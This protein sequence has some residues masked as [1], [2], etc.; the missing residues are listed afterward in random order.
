MKT[1]KELSAEIRKR[2][3]NLAELTKLL[4]EQRGHQR[5][6]ALAPQKEREQLRRA[7]AATETDVDDEELALTVLREQLGEAEKAERIEGLRARVAHIRRESARGM[8][9]AKKMETIAGEYRAL[10]RELEAISV[11]IRDSFELTRELG[12]EKVPSPVVKNALTLFQDPA[13]QTAIGA[14]VRELREAAAA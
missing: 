4:A 3:G 1:T 8:E 14:R 12:E 13:E 11:L 5:E 7:I 6:L 2:E 10:V 9:I